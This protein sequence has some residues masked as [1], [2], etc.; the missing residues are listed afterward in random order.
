ML[1]RQIK[2]TTNLAK[3]YF[4]TSIVKFPLVLSKNGLLNGVIAIS[5]IGSVLSGLANILLSRLSKKLN[6]KTYSSI[7]ST[8]MQ[9][10]HHAIHLTTLAFRVLIIMYSVDLS[11]RFLVS[12]GISQRSEDL[13]ALLLL[14]ILLITSTV[15]P[16]K[17]NILFNSRNLLNMLVIA[18]VQT[19]KTTMQPKIDIWNP[20]KKY[21]DSL[22]LTLACFT[23]QLG[24][25][26]SL[27]IDE[28]AI[29]CGNALATAFYLAI[30]IGGYMSTMKPDVNWL[31][32]IE[33]DTARTLSSLFLLITN[34]LTYSLQ[35]Q[36]I[37]EDLQV[38]CGK[39]D[40]KILTIVFNIILTVLFVLISAKYVAS[41]FGAI[42][43]VLLSSLV[44]LVF[45]A[46]FYLRS[47]DRRSL[48]ALG[49]LFSGVLLHFVG[50][51]DLITTLVK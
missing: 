17:N 25:V 20:S 31:L 19:V 27:E 51:K 34:I 2:E 7:S 40:S 41:K 18:S 16:L 23:Q 24:I 29:L 33:N 39:T 12:A 13:Q 14:G 32:N 21:F 44:M 48:F 4:I 37:T 50:V 11:L 5:L 22:G 6:E 38:L 15:L 47:I 10:S 43:C 30:G 1:T 26:N 42:S 3:V 45:P 28:K 49:L 9:K 36:P 35:I 46:L 8:T